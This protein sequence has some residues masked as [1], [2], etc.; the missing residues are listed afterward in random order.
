MI[1]PDGYV[2]VLDFG[3]AKLVEQ[4]KPFP[5]LDEETPGNQTAKGMILGTVNYMS[6]EQAKGQPVDERTDVF[7]FGVVI[8]EMLAG[9]T[10]FA[11][12]STPE[13][14]ANLIN[15]EPQPLEYFVASVPNE[16]KHI[17]DK[18]LRKN[19]NE[20][21][22]TMNDVLMGLKDAR[23]NLT[24]DQKL[25]RSNSPNIEIAPTV[26]QTT[27]RDVDGPTTATQY[28]FSQRLE[29]IKPVAAIAL[30]TFLIGVISLGYYFLHGRN[31]ASRAG[32]KKTIAVL[33]LK[34]I[35]TSTRDEIYEIGIADSLILNIG[36]INGFNV[37]PLSATRKYSTLDQDPLAAGK[38]QQVD[39]VLAST[40]QLADGKI[41]VTA[42]LL[43]VANGQVEET[44][45][46]GEKDAANVFVVQDAIAGEIGNQLLARFATKST[47]QTAKR[48][49]TNEEAYRL[50]LQGMYLANNRTPE[51]SRKAVETLEQSVRLDANYAQAWA[52]LAYAYRQTRNPEGHQKSIEAINRALALDPNLADAYSTL[53]E[54]K[55]YYEYD[56]PSAEQACKRALEL[57]L[58]SSQ[59]HEI[60]SR[61]L[62]SRA[63]HDEAIGE[64][65]AAIDLEPTLLFYQQN[66][67]L[68][69]YYARRYP[70]AIA[71]FKR[72][73]ELNPNFSSTYY[74]LTGASSARRAPLS[75]FAIGAE[76]LHHCPRR[77]AGAVRAGGVLDRRR[78]GHR[79]RRVVGRDRDLFRV[80]RRR[81]DAVDRATG[82]HA[83]RL[84]RPDRRTARQG[85][86]HHQ[87]PAA[88]SGAVRPEARSDHAAPD[89]AG[90]PRHR[91][92]CD[93]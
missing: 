69:L 35:N 54:N 68:A 22:Q 34:P 53:C 44:Y 31:A 27:N 76:R 62:M 60:Y 78:H 50:Y 30:A 7:S 82:G 92:E 48:G 66:Y 20:R 39:Y 61:F 19:A 12:D 63:R 45:R 75:R 58:A 2:K 40:Y 28:R 84:R 42:Q 3:L 85:R 1:R 47:N 25:A 5:G 43:N 87:P 80:P 73:L 6:P 11:G 70:E 88:R 38:E 41:R 32:G 18:T 57:N 46:S 33:P 37:R 72:V 51:A 55:M 74:W 56:F 90:I 9:R 8:Y 91:A 13:T 65:K 77:Q 83:I 86:S 49:T 24:A 59:A 93:P 21:Y 79:A 16:L 29:R 15:A 64:I 26:G 81:A 67:G 4:N 36:S 17:V 89:H 71:Q 10:P 23:A 14:F 52:G